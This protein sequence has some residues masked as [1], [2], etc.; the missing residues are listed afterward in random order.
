M[1]RLHL[2]R[3][4]LAEPAALAAKGVEMACRGVPARHVPRRWQLA[5]ETIAAAAAIGHFP[6]TRRRRRALQPWLSGDGLRSCCPHVFDPA[7][8]AR[9]GRV[10]PGEAIFVQPEFLG[11]FQRELLPAIGV[12]FVLVSANSDADAPGAHA[13]LL[14]DRRVLAWFANNVTSAHP[15]LQPVPIGLVDRER[16][17]AALETARAAVPTARDLWLLAAFATETHPERAEVRARLAGEPGV[18]FPSRLA[19]EEYFRLLTR[20]RFVLSPRGAGLDCHR[21]WEALLC[22]AIP[23]VRTSPLDSLLEELPVLIVRDWSEVTR[24]RLTQAEPDLR[25]RGWD[26]PIMQLGTWAQRL[27]AFSN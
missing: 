11:I 13:Q 2:L 5:F 12:P 7:R 22:G 3:R 8:R 14:E 17:R 26:L 25:R 21:T 18:Q 19:P 20:S 15:K 27:A 9:L 23:V 24:A 4:L 10:Q 1:R 6:F 16:H